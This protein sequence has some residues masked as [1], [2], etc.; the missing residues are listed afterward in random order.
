MLDIVNLEKN[1]LYFDYSIM[2][3]KGVTDGSYKKFAD[4]EK[5][6]SGFV[7][8]PGKK[9]PDKKTH[10]LAVSLFR[11]YTL[12]KDSVDEP[13]DNYKTEFLSLVVKEFSDLYK[14][15]FNIKKDHIIDSY[16]IIK[17]DPVNVL[18]KE[19]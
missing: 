12:L 11:D 1:R 15:V 4:A 18:R 6:I 13:F 10:N 14:S 3:L 8:S 19:F 5:I 16:R 9:G 17:E 2:M 7:R